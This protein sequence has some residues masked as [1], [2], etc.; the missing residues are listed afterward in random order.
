MNNDENNENNNIFIVKQI[1]DNLHNYGIKYL[2]EC[3]INMIKTTISYINKD[4]D[5][6][7]YDL[8]NNWLLTYK[9]K[10][11]VECCFTGKKIFDPIQQLNMRIQSHMKYCCDC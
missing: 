4:K 8:I 3:N 7:K 9:H 11:S 5:E 2:Q 6:E 10:K 1:E